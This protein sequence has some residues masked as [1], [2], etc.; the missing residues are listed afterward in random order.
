MGSGAV[1]ALPPISSPPAPTLSDPRRDR[2]SRG[3]DLANLDG[4]QKRPPHPPRR[5]APR[6]R[7]QQRLHALPCRLQQR[8]EHDLCGRREGLLSAT[9]GHSDESVRA[10]KSL[11]AAD[12]FALVPRAI[13]LTK[14]RALPRPSGCG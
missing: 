2:A 3:G 1:A 11:A 6:R 13:L 9:A 4:V 7:R 14:A 8:D 10:A 12:K 5:S